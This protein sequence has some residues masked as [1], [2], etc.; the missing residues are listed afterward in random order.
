MSLVNIL[1]NIKQTA[2]A[3]ESIPSSHAGCVR[4]RQALLSIKKECDK[5]RK[6]LMEHS[7][8]LKQSRRP[9]PETKSESET[10]TKSE[11][12]DNLL[13]LERPKLERSDATAPHVVKLKR[14]RKVKPETTLS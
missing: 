8:A 2:E 12:D 6:G 7:K 10:E 14:P 3:L 11:S 9:D 5:L 13:P 4:Q 1:S